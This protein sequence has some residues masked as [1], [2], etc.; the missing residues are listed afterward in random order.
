[1]CTDL[2]Q[3]LNHTQI[4]HSLEKFLNYYLLIDLIIMN[5]SYSY[6]SASDVVNNSYV[7]VSCYSIHCILINPQ[8]YKD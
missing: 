2:S 4:C 3:V 5:I 7:L 8:I 6:F 1:M